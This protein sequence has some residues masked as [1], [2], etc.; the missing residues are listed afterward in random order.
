MREQFNLEVPDAAFVKASV[1]GVSGCADLRSIMVAD[2]PIADLPDEVF[3]CTLAEVSDQDVI[4][5]KVTAILEGDEETAAVIEA[6]KPM[7]GPLYACAGDLLSVE[8]FFDLLG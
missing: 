5:L 3:G 8:E 6:L 2:V 4:N 7:I 1:E